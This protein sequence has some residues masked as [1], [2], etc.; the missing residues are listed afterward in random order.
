[1]S[2][3]DTSRSISRSFSGPS[4]TPEMSRQDSK[5]ACVYAHTTKRKRRVGF[6][7]LGHT[8]PQPVHHQSPLFEDRLCGSF[9]PVAIHL[10]GVRF[11][12]GG[13]GS[14]CTFV[15]EP[16]G[17]MKGQRVDCPVVSRQHPQ[18]GRCF[19]TTQPKSDKNPLMSL[20]KATC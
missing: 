10:L 2:Q 9:N 3:P 12:S 1:M 19:R 6:L 8:F 16:S 5:S 13:G 7:I 17:P 4:H 14:Q 20:A 15:I 18:S 11:F